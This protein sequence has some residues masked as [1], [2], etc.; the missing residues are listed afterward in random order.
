MGVKP[1][2]SGSNPV[3]DIV[4]AFKLLLTLRGSTLS[5]SIIQAQT[6]LSKVRGIFRNESTSDVFTYLCLYG[7]ATAWVLQCKLG[8]PEATTYRALKQLRSLGFIKPAIKVHKIRNS[9]GGPRPKIW[10]LEGASMED[11]AGALKLHLR[12]LSPKYRIAEEVAQS[13]L[14]DY[15]IPRQATEISYREI[16]IQVKELKIPFMAPDVADL[17]ASYLHERGIK[18]WR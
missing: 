16:I 2:E 12:M 5:A 9:K 15:I 4:Y 6:I 18:V 14:D 10:A 17:A 13:I 7:A 8:M 11:I 3:Y 1:P